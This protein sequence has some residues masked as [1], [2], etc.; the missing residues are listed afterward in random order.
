[1][2]AAWLTGLA[3]ATE[4]PFEEG[5]VEA[6]AVDM[7][8]VVGALPAEVRMVAERVAA[9]PLVARM[10]AISR[11]LLD[12]PYV[13]DPLGEGV[14][15]DPDPF[16]RYDVFDCLTFVEEVLALALAGDPAHAS[17]VRNSL[18]YG[19]S[20]PTYVNRRH[21]MEL[22]WIP[23][24][25]GDGWLVD[26]TSSYGETVILEREWT[27]AG[28]ANWAGRK[29]FHHPDEA[30]PVGTM[31]LEVLPLATAREA[32]DRFRPG[33]V[34]LTVR[35]D[36]PWKPLW[37]THVGFVFEG[38]HGLVVRHATKMGTGRTRDHHLDWYLEHIGTYGNWTT[39]GV[40]LLEPVEQGPRR[41][42]P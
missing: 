4:D 41:S 24:V 42:R 37:I 6:P 7:Q 29:S 14:G 9:E 1:M 10:D 13:A 38:E 3:L 19:D 26:S 16:A 5:G 31:R 15:V 32:A 11:A 2:I 30:L 36:K 39:L 12:R 35:E 8:V 20:E 28:W 23:G 21:F 27:A 34:L 33:S 25:V 22:Q 17:A 40:A 18:R